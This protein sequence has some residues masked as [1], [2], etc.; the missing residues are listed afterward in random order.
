MAA[1]INYGITNEDLNGECFIAGAEGE[2]EEL[3]EKNE[4][5]FAPD[6][7]AAA[8]SAAGSVVTFSTLQA[9]N[10]LTINIAHSMRAGVPARE[11]ARI[12]YIRMLAVRNGLISP[13]FNIQ[14]NN[15]RYNHA[16]RVTE[17]QAVA[18]ADS[19]VFTDVNKAAIQASLSAD[20]KKSIRKHFSDMVCCVAYI[21]RVRA[22]HYRDDLQDRYISLWARCLHK[23]SDLPMDWKYIA[24]DALHAIMPGHLD[25]FWDDCVVNAKCAGALIKRFDSAPAGVAGVLALERGLDDVMMLFPHVVDQ[26]PDAYEYFRN[27]VRQV[28]D[29]RWGGSINSRFYGA[30]RIRVD[31]GKIGALASVVM[32]IYEQLATDSKLRESPALQRLAQTAPA[33]GGAI[34]IAARRAVQDERMTLL[35]AVSGSSANVTD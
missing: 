4:V 2:V 26:V 21:F 3:I 30:T 10:F 1:P 20:V 35:G 8:V 5:V 34:G 12:A 14:T 32:G 28:G 27:I 18:L 17:V 15:V 11:A 7:P 25:A 16:V 22:H 24:T 23:D 19:D 6:T 9:N 13:D 29:S 33:T 31:E